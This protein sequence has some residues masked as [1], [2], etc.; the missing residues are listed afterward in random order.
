MSVYRLGQAQIAALTRRAW[1]GAGETFALRMT[2]LDATGAGPATVS[3]QGGSV[4]ALFPTGDAP[5]QGA[6]R[7]VLAALAQDMPGAAL[8]R[9]IQPL[10]CR[11]LDDGRIDLAAP[12][13]FHA[14]YVIRT[15]GATLERAA[16]RC[17][18]PEADV[19]VTAS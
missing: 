6:W 8:R 15:Y 4:V 16:S 14:H 3:V 12:S 7:R 19:R 9:W 13:R 2:S 17:G 10:T 1:T 18:S 11:R 5:G